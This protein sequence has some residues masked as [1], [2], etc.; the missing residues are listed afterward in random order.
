VLLDVER[1]RS[2]LL[3]QYSITWLAIL[4]LVSLVPQ[5]LHRTCVLLWRLPKLAVPFAV[6]MVSIAV[7]HMIIFLSS[8]RTHCGGGWRRVVVV[9]SLTLLFV[10]L[11]RFCCP[12][13]SSFAD[14]RGAKTPNHANTSTIRLH[15]LSTL[16][17]ITSSTL[18]QW[19]YLSPIILLPDSLRLDRRRCPSTIERWPFQAEPRVRQ[20][21]SL[22]QSVTGHEIQ[23]TFTSLQ[24]DVARA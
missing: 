13:R 6:Q 14:V 17:S 11:S 15:V 7:L 19:A 12:R 5:R 8:G 23:S 10:R 2:W 20:R 16:T 3:H 24:E 1:A 22:E 18:Q 21:Q 4:V 9:M